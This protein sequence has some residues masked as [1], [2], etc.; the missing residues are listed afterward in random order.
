MVNEHQIFITVDKKYFAFGT[1]IS[2][3]CGFTS[4]DDIDISPCKEITYFQ[5]KNIIITKICTSISLNNNTFW[6]THQNKLYGH[7]YGQLGL[8]V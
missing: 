7:D 2:G 1:N 4:P 3:Q 5:I 8:A 6:I